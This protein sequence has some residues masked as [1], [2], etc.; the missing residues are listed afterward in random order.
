MSH[1][2]DAVLIALTSG[3]EIGVDV[4]EIS[5]GVIRSEAIADACLNAEESL[6]LAHIPAGGRPQNLLR[7][8]TH[9]EACLKAIGCG[10][11]MPPQDL[12]VTFTDCE[13][14]MIHRTN[15][16]GRHPLFGYDLPYGGDY[17]GAVVGTNQFRELR[18]YR[19]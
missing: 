16:S 19:L 1:S 12:T 17:V 5:S 3:A 4:E 9:K 8:W 14:S 7:F 13:H 2:S 15:P 10:L 6:L 11:S 18:F